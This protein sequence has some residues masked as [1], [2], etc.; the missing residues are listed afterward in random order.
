ME[1]NYYFGREGKQFGPF[2]KSQLK[3][4]AAEGKIKQTDRIWK[5]GMT[6][7]LPANR[8]KG[9]FPS[10]PNQDKQLPLSPLNQPTNLP[11]GLENSNRSTN[12]FEIPILHESSSNSQNQNHGPTPKLGRQ[13]K[14][15]ALT[16]GTDALKAFKALASNPV[17]GMKT[18]FANL[19]PQRAMIVG[20]IFGIVFELLVLI[21]FEIHIQ[22][23]IKIPAI[24]ISVRLIILGLIPLISTTSGCAIVRIIFKG[25]GNIQGDIF[26]AGSSL[27]PFGIGVFISGFLG[28]GNIEVLAALGVFTITTTILMMYSGCTTVQEIPDAA[29]TLSVPLIFLVCIYISKIIFT[30]VFFN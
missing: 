24:Q 28:L 15:V 30:S 23:F 7:W 10:P 4:L 29:A 26:I 11:P 2:T 17:G 27:L 16:A 1:T 3:D 18:A 5:H 9:L 6:E 21:G 22:S 8:V 25:K 12:D 20:I 14:E 13:A 19:G